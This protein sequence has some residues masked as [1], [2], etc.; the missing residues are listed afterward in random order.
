MNVIVTELTEDGVLPQLL[1]VEQ[2]AVAEH[3][4]W[5]GVGVALRLPA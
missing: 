1:A 2:H 3:A 5:L 4:F